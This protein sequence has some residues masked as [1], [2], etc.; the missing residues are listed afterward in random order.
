MGLAG[1]RQIV[2]QHGGDISL[3]SVEGAG[4]TFT[5]RLPMA[6]P[7]AGTARPAA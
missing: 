2:G 7:V 1:A 5:V 6:A 4:A 3:T